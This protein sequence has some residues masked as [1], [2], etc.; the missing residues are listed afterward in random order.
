VRV[1]MGSSAGGGPRGGVGEGLD[2]VESG[3]V[4]S[5]ECG[6]SGCVV[7]PP[8]QRSPASGWRPPCRPGPC[9]RAGGG[10]EG[11]RSPG[12]RPPCLTGPCA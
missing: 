9:A 12:W 1:W 3:W 11:R 5:V 7:A 6:W 2:G 4:G 8:G 10:R